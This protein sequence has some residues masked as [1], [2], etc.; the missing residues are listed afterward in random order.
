MKVIL[1]LRTHTTR[2]ATSLGGLY[3]W[4]QDPHRPGSRLL[5]L[6]L[7]L[8]G[9][10]ACALLLSTYATATF[11]GWRYL[12]QV[13]GT[14]VPYGSVVWPG[15]WDGILTERARQAEADALQ[16]LQEG[17]WAEGIQGL[18]FSVARFPEHRQAALLL[19]AFYVE[20]NR[21]RL[22]Q[23]VLELSAQ[24]QPHPLSEVAMAFFRVA[25]YNGDP[26]AILDYTQPLLERLSDF[27]PRVQERLLQTH[28]EALLAAE[29]GAQ[30]LELCD[31][32]QSD[33][34]FALD[35]VE[36]R[37]EA[38][39]QLHRPAEVV[40]LIGTLPQDRT[41]QQPKLLQLMARAF[42]KGGRE[43]YV[44]ATLALL[45][46]QE[47]PTL[48][49]AQF[50]MRTLADLDPE[51]PG[52]E[53]FAPAVVAYF[54]PQE[55]D[56]R[57]L[58]ALAS[59]IP[60]PSVCQ[61]ALQ[62]AKAR[63]YPLET[64][65]AEA[66]LAEVRAGR[67]PAAA[68]DFLTYVR[69]QREA[70]PTVEWRPASPSGRLALAVFHHLQVPDEAFS[71]PLDRLLLVDK[72]PPARLQELAQL[73]ANQGAVP[74]ARQVAGHGFDHFPAHAGARALAL[75]LRELP[76][77][78][79][80]GH[81]TLD[82]PYATGPEALAAVDEALREK[83]FSEAQRILAEV[84]RQQPDW[85][86]AQLPDWEWRELRLHLLRDG[87]SL[88]AAKAETLSSGLEDERRNLLSA[89]GQLEQRGQQAEAE[90]VKEALS[91][92]TPEPERLRALV[93]SLELMPAESAGSSVA[94]PD[95]SR[96][97]ATWEALDTLLGQGAYTEA[98]QYVRDLQAARPPWLERQADA[99]A[100]RQIQLYLLRGD[101][102]L[103]GPLIDRFAKAD[104]AHVVALEALAR[105]LEAE[106][107]HEAAQFLRDRLAQ[108]SGG[109]AVL[110]P[111][112]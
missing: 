19:A 60:A 78:E 28:F 16:A 63:G 107:R 25:R 36:V 53:R 33:E 27:G 56:L 109:T 46:Q 7:R 59:T 55:N 11:L 71:E 96:P 92:S 106:A 83:Q 90:R 80:R 39:L 2:L 21:P 22:A 70:N 72:L 68:E 13:K 102:V 66:F 69:T 40:S 97:Q 15:A 54:A 98:A 57:G 50:I 3:G 99:L 44:H 82:L 62:E 100:E 103:A 64:F 89:L 74:A 34:R 111:A 112:P 30:V 45:L 51:H 77:P 49:T 10:G 85:R 12:H 9:L 1:G 24:A 61:A 87:A 14:A 104:A 43:E 101:L 58:A 32:L 95:F 37:A 26:D 20:I 48:R 88:A 47:K 35:L 52:L 110:S 23:E 75:K 38:L 76:N 105:R 4:R 29:K 42:V 17:R 108:R 94:S 93:A 31:R 73:L 91:E 86:E 79:G 8:L 6:N 81:P 65:Q 5:V 18:R 41:L 84:R 67:A